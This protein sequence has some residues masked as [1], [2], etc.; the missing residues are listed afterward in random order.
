MHQD[1][2]INLPDHLR[3]E[4]VHL[5]PGNSSRTKRRGHK[6]RTIARLRDINTDDI[7]LQ[8]EA[9]CSRYDTPSRK[10]G[11]AIAVG[12]LKFAYEN[13]EKLAARGH[14][15]DEDQTLSDILNDRIPTYW[16]P[17]LP[18]DR[19]PFGPLIKKNA[20]FGDKLPGLE[21]A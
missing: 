7:V 11:R 14:K 18:E 15:K 17:C 16:P 19:G 1:L 10:V 5:H 6:Y 3:L 12:R 13:P 8:T 21:R 2:S 4:V 20:E 9:R